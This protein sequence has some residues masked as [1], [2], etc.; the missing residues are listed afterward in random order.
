MVLWL[1]PRH[2]ALETLQGG[3][4]GS[5]GEKADRL[6]CCVRYHESIGGEAWERGTPK[7]NVL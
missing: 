2:F 4:G 1:I 7:Y 3:M 5:E 6:Y